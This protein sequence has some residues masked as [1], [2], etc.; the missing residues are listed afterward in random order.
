MAQVTVTNTIHDPGD[1]SQQYASVVLR[2][3]GDDD[4]EIEVYV[5][6]TGQSVAGAYQPSVDST[7]TWSA[8]VWPSAQLTPNSVRLRCVETIPGR[9]SVV[10]YLNPQPSPSTQKAF[11]IESSQPTSAPIV[12][13]GGN[14]STVYTYSPFSGGGA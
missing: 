9:P 1:G 11:A 3:V 13:T 10:T 2:W 7:G 12:E 5:T 4:S 14:S 6:A 8:S